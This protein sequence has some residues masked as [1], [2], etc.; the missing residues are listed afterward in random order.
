MDTSTRAWLNL[1]FGQATGSAVVLLAIDLQQRML[2]KQ[3]L[4]VEPISA[5]GATV[6]RISP[7]TPVG[8]IGEPAAFLQAAEGSGLRNIASLSRRRS[9]LHDRWR[10]PRRIRTR[11]Q[12]GQVHGRIYK[13][14]R[15]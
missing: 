8:Q 6:S 7:D 12:I 10:L 13:K 4:E 5:P 14:E 1:V 3:S 9:P 11:R 15:V 2:E